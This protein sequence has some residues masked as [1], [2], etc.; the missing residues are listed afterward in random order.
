MKNLKRLPSVRKRQWECFIVDESYFVVIYFCMPLHTQVFNKT[1]KGYHDLYIKMIH[2]VK[3]TTLCFAVPAVN[4]I[5]SLSGSPL[6]HDHQV[7]DRRYIIVCNIACDF[8][9]QVYYCTLRLTQT[10]TSVVIFDMTITSVALGEGTFLNVVYSMVLLCPL[11]DTCFQVQFL[12]K[13]SPKANQ[14][15][16][17]VNCAIDL[18]ASQPNFLLSW[19]MHCL[20]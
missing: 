17:A 7:S 8:I 13:L 15:R 14:T 9:H 10:C 2:I 1:L 4:F 11:V 6:M 3:D 19:F 18:L 20:S 5:T 16:S 12:L